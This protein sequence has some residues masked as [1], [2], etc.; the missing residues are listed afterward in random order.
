MAQV[1]ASDD[2]NHIPSWLHHC[3]MA[4]AQGL[5]NVMYSGRYQPAPTPTRLTVRADV[6]LNTMGNPSTGSYV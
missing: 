2:A 4:Q 6:H 5:E 3:Q 1:F